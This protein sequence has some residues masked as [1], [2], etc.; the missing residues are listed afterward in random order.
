MRGLRVSA[1]ICGA[2]RLRASADSRAYLR[3]AERR[4]APPVWA[5]GARRGR[6]GGVGFARAFRGALERLSRSARRGFARHPTLLCARF[7]GRYGCRLGLCADAFMRLHRAFFEV[8]AGD[9]EARYAMIFGG[10]IH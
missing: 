5:L 3:A 8:V 6:R 4:F 2:A 1:R 7:A 10:V 9:M